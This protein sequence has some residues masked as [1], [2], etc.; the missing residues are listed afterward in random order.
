MS[1]CTDKSET[2]LCFD[3]IFELDPSLRHLQLT[4]CRCKTDVLKL[5]QLHI[6]PFHWSKRPYLLLLNKGNKGVY[7]YTLV[8]NTLTLYPS[9]TFPLDMAYQKVQKKQFLEPDPNAS[10]A[11]A[12]EFIPI[13]GQSPWEFTAIQ[14]LSRFEHHRSRGTKIY[15]YVRYSADGMGGIEESLKDAERFDSLR[16]HET[17]R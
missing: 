4:G 16:M 7:L 11:F 12:W 15:C 13:Q 1:L 3:R 9:R 10:S 2:W 5:G 17:I 6:I 8:V 14:M